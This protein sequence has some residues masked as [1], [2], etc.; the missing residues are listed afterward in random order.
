MKI[1]YKWLQDYFDKKLPEP[2]KL[3]ELLTL[4]SYEVE[5]VSKADDDYVL[6]IDVLPNRAH[7]SLSHRGIA[8]EIS[9]LLNLKLKKD[10]YSKDIQLRGKASQL[11]DI[12]VEDQ[13]LCRRY[14]AI[15]L[16]GVKTGPSPRWLKERLSA[17]GQKSINNVVD[18]LNFIMF[19][20]GQP[21]HAFDADK[22]SKED[23]K[24]KIAVRFGRIGEKMTALDGKEYEV[25]K[26]NLLII[27]GTSDMP[28]GI[29]GVK[30][31][32]IAEIDDDTVDIIIESANF[33]P[34]SVRKT[35]R[36]LKLR[37][38]SS[39]RFEN[40][41]SPELTQ[42]GI[43]EAVDLIIKIAGGD[44]E[45]Y[46]DFYPHKRN[47]YKV[48]VSVHEVNKLL[49]TKI[50]EKEIE[51]IFKRFNFEYKK[52]KPIDEI[53]KL[54]PTFE[55]VPYKYGASVSYDAPKLFDCSGFVKY[56]FAHAGINV[57]R[58]SIDQFLTGTPIE[59]NELQDGDLI[60]SKGGKPHHREG[61]QDGIGHVGIYLG[62][63]KVI[64]ACGDD[65]GSK[66]VI[67]DY[68]E[69]VKF[70]GEE[71]RGFKRII[72]DKN[73]RIVVTV[74]FERLDLKIKEDLIEEIG[75]IY[76]YEKI[77]SQSPKKSEKVP[78][79]NKKFYY[80]DKIRQFLAEEG[81]SEVYT[82]SF[83][84]NGEVEIENPFASDKNF[85][86]K[87]LFY[88]L[89][90]A[91]QRNIKNLPLL[92]GDNIKIFEIGNV[93]TKDEEHISLGIVHSGG[94]GKVE[95]V[96]NKLSETLGIK[97]EGK[98]DLNIFETNFSELVEK[99]PEPPESY[100]KFERP[101]KDIKYKPIS[102]YP[103]ALRDIA[104]FVP[105]NIKDID[106]LAIIK[107]ESGNLLVSTKLFDEFKKDD[108]I[109]YAFNLV[110]QS[111]EKTLSDEEVNKIMEKVTNTLN[112]SNNWQVR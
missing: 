77:K 27:D 106:V 61:V 1:S 25:G 97:I 10:P 89:N 26:N 2:K 85:L 42:V 76:G 90:D 68:K 105:K 16:K 40:E 53:L 19:D 92:N 14:S 103:F 31:G 13:M 111:H 112:S 88:G 22:L 95:D 37:T 3:A 6:S 34:V 20:I 23:G 38:D 81:F 47:P 60:F 36:A 9:A 54:A 57:P 56:V 58:V 41:I 98:K 93:F 73:E 78:D 55:G 15:V 45:G 50:S 48:G 11:V 33:D 71:F 43:A 69:S 94:L 99:L 87:D 101:A 108:K 66:V 30:G 96:V 84:N 44:I 39:T 63:S 62:D 4:H 8:K 100:E 107:K 18:A 110:F 65:C 74:P 46:A 83:R 75:R 52:V 104:I 91:E 28:I 109:S 17:V 7:D 59:E 51:S 67:E 24:Y 72:A 82:Y 29:A 12:S 70:S 102:S 21:L 35:S 5:D 86:C 32:V 64:H 80:A 79:V 49:G